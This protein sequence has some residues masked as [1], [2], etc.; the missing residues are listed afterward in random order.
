M[1]SQFTGHAADA[2]RQLAADARPTAI[3]ARGEENSIEA[4]SDSHLFGFDFVT[5][6]TLMN[7][8]NHHATANVKE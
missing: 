8:G 7:L 6:G 2:L 1:L 4:S 3:C 5:L